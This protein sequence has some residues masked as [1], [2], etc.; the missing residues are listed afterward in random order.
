M[1]LKKTLTLLLLVGGLVL[2]NA[3]W[4]QNAKPNLPDLPVGKK[5]PNFTLTDIDGKTHQLSD[6][7]GKIVVLEWNNPFCP[8][9]VP[10]YE[11]SGMTSLQKRYTQQGVVW[12]TVNSTNS[13][14]KDYRSADELKTTLAAYDPGYTAYLLDTDGTTGKAYGAKTTP[15]IFIIDAKGKLAYRGAIDDAPDTEGGKNAKVNYAAKTLT[16]LLAKQK[17]TTKET[18]QYGCS[19]KYKK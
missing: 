4:A 10:H 16:E 7:K 5:A 13:E 3:L 1:L 12:L 8:F 19:V 14:H 15:H 17:V 2:S 18:K 11:N 6:F 9:V